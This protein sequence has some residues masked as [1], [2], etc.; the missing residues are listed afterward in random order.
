[1]PADLP[2][3]TVT[4][5][6]TDIEGSTQLLQQLGRQRY[7]EVLEQHRRL[8]RETASSH[9]G[10]EVEMQGDSFLLAFRRARDAVACAAAIQRRQP[11]ADPRI[12][13]RIG[14]HTG[15]PDVTAERL[16]VGIDVHRAAR[17]MSVAHGGQVVLSQQSSQLVASEL[18]EDLQVRHL[19]EF[20]LRSI[21]QPES[22][23]QLVI[24]GAPSEYPPL[25]GAAPTSTSSRRRRIRVGTGLACVVAAGA[26]AL[27]YSLTRADPRPLVAPP[28]SVAVID[29]A[30]DRVA[31]VVPV[32]TTPSAIVGSGS[33]VWT[34]N[35]G[36]QTI[37]RIETATR[38]RTRTISAGAV[39]S[40]IAV[41]DG[42]IWVAD[43]EADQVS[44]LD[45]AG[46]VEATIRLGIHH[47]RRDFVPP[48]VVLAAGSG[49]VWATGGDLTTVVIDATA[50]RVVQRTDGFP[51]VGSD[52]SPGGPDVA[53]GAAGVWATDGRDEL[54][55]LD[56]V[57]AERIQLGGFGGDAGIEAVTVGDDAVW[58]AGAGVAWRVRTQPLRATGTY[59]AGA[60]P[61]GVALGGGSVWIANA[62]DGTVSRIRL[63]SGE[64][65]TIPVGGTPGD[66]TF[67]S[68]LVWVTVD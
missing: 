14:I 3:G 57:P 19:G 41:A 34:L 11:E 31:S 10:Q 56:A 46:A 28:N 54:F 47:R 2:S 1:M 59:P 22:I 6:F 12:R 52:G 16:Y 32:G 55:R 45:E 27:V 65:T 60:G 20:R 36:D 29:P 49:K 30:E 38:E 17:L 44:V 53:V 66:L 50:R 5:L 21:N 25:R 39:A 13:V 42:D 40:D 4:L 61:R 35:T 48:R 33:A 68:G 43:A 58:A 24:D 23:S 18:P 51:D 62:F 64:A 37:S 15:E 8:V 7:S 67:A 63:S 9:S 26:V